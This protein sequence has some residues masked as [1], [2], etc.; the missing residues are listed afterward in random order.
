MANA[1]A[2]NGAELVLRIALPGVLVQEGRIACANEAAVRLSGRNFESDLVGRDFRDL[3]ADDAP[4]LLAARLRAGEAGH[5]TTRV[6]PALIRRANGSTVSV[7]VSLTLLDGAA[8][9]SI[10]ALFPRSGWLDQRTELL[11]ALNDRFRDLLDAAAEYVIVQ[12][13]QGRMLMVNRAV[14]ELV[15]R[16]EPELR[17]RSMLDFMP[18]SEHAAVLERAA[19]R[20]AGSSAAYTYEASVMAATGDE[21]RIKVTSAP[22]M[23]E[24][25]PI[26]VLVIGRPADDRLRDAMRLQAERDAAREANRLKSE[27][28][29]KMSHEVR[30]PMHVILGMAEI[31]LDG[32][33]SPE[34]EDL[35]RRIRASAAGLVALVDSIL[36]LS[37][38]EAG[39]LELQRRSFRL[40]GVVRDALEPLRFVATRTGIT[41]DSWVDDDVPDHVVGDPDRLRQVLINLTANGVKFTTVGG[42]ELRVSRAAAAAGE[43][44]HVLFAVRDTGVGIPREERS[45]IFEP[46]R[47]ADTRDDL[48]RK[49]AGL[50]LAIARELVALMGGRIWVESEVGRG[51]V[52]YFTA[53]FGEDTV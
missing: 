30:T 16:S 53:T 39:R 32:P 23:S 52:F 44:L 8:G 37:R 41:L 25:K 42:V 34:A 15:G 51:S 47:Q 5:E 33:L 46:F 38:I 24:G 12:D 9:T 11:A 27:F 3:F 29:A 36:D 20:L 19:S 6:V 14:Q 50:G 45:R 26:A 49:G 40:R 18:T 1:S 21:V 7:E 43:S 2:P 13:L 31:A 48:G 10:L 17:G 22:L 28:L 4:H 35:I